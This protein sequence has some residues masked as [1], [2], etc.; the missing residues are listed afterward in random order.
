MLVPES[1]VIGDREN[2]D[3]CPEQSQRFSHTLSHV[4]TG[5]FLLALSCVA[6]PLLFGCGDSSEETAVSSLVT[7]PVTDSTDVET[8]MPTTTELGTSVAP[9]TSVIS[10]QTSIGIYFIKGELMSVVGRL[11]ETPDIDAALH[12]LLLGP[13][14][15]E[16]QDGVTSFIP[17]GTRLLNVDVADSTAFIDF[18]H[19]FASGGGSLSMMGRIAEVVYT[20]TAFADIDRVTIRIDGVLVEQIGGEGIDVSEISRTDL[21]DFSPLILV[22]SPVPHEVVGRDIHIAGM[23]NTYEA[24]INYQVISTDGTVIYEGYTMATSGTG[25][26]GTFDH[27]IETL[28]ATV[29]GDFVL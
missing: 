28:P 1:L 2:T 6:S 29:V 12:S 22:D 27:V 15:V 20:A 16:V 19:E 14:A 18:S 21:I 25:T 9:T 5:H 17:E 26:W 3:F 7:L 24:G 13:T 10:Q 8:T 4:K 11:V 23:S